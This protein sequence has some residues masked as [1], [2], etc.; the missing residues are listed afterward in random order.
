MNQ[1]CRHEQPE[2]SRV[3]IVPAHDRY[4]RTYARALLRWRDSIRQEVAPAH[5]LD[6]ILDAANERN[7]VQPGMQRAAENTLAANCASERDDGNGR[8]NIGN[9]ARQPT[10]QFS[11]G[12]APELCG[13]GHTHL[14]SKFRSS[15]AFW[16]L[17][18][19]SRLETTGPL[20]ALQ[21][22]G[23]VIGFQ[24]AELDQLRAEL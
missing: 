10:G 24:H 11:P 12:V 23:G 16:R 7:R 20:A 15:S 4:S 3:A 9:R 13:P 1:I 21:M 18:A 14:E 5:G 19:E 17:R 22:A 6:Q 2:Q 8:A